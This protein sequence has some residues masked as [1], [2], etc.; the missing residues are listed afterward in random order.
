MGVYK[1]QLKSGGELVVTPTSWSIE[2]YFPGPDMRYN[3]EFFSI[4]ENDIDKYI[5]AWKNNFE[6]Y[7]ELKSVIDLEGT[8][9]TMGE[10]GMKISIGGWREGVFINWWDMNVKDASE[11][12][13]IIT[14]YEAAKIKAK[15]VQE[16]LKS[17]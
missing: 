6:K 16:I 2:Y 8:Y 7:L 4:R 15:K 12:N 10:A 14:D 17:L 9:E 3:G 11:I 1:E 13:Q 5:Y